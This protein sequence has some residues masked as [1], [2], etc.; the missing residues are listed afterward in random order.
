M[1][2]EYYKQN[3]FGEVVELDLSKVDEED[4][5]DLSTKTDE[6]FNVF[7]LTDAIGAR[8]KRQAWILYRQAIA[9]GLVADELFWRVAWMVK[10]LLLSAK[11]SSVEETGLNPFV[12]KKAKG[13]LRNWKV[14]E[15]EKLSET[16]VTGY[17]NV[18]RG[19][20]EM[21]TMIEKILLNL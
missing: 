12:Y 9:K 13:F 6:R 16:L 4:E 21:E 10:S 7:A 18:R 1:D 14:E 19:I 20:G 17:H 3:L 11:A 5:P 8:D 15:L 2:D